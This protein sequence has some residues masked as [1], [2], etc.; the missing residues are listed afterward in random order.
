MSGRQ[1]KFWA[2]VPAA[3]KGARMKSNVPK[4]YLKLGHQSVLEHTLDSLFSCPAIAG[5][6][7]VLSANDRY[8]TK[9]NYRLTSEHIRG[10][11]EIVA[12]GTKRYDSVLSG[13]RHLSGIADP[14]DRVLVHDAARPCVRRQDI[15]LLIERVG[16]SP[17]GGLLGM[18]VADTMKRIKNEQVISTVE[19]EGLW[20]ALTP[21]L[22]PLGI[23]QL[24]LSAAIEKGQRIT[25]EAFAME[26]AG[27]HPLMVEGRADNIKVTLPADL[28]RAAYYLQ[29][30]G[31]V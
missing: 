21:Q 6:V 7:L 28:A 4:Q 29:I 10:P 8:W 3:G 13:L 25:D 16:Q 11:L 30:R 19:R 1:P 20:H 14:D 12:G 22:F 26:Q 15:E 24:A 2:L 5:I 31:D 23:L 27:Y 9:L 17:D 18:P